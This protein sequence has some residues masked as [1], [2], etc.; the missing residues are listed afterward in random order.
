MSV[1]ILDC[2]LRDGGYVNEWNFGAKTI[3]QIV[4]NLTNACIDFVEIGF[5][6]SKPYDN[7]RTKFRF[8]SDFSPFIPADRK[9]TKYYGMITF[10][11]YD[12]ND[13][14]ENDQKSVDGFRII[15][16]KNQRQE[17][18]QYCQAVKDKGYDIFINPMHTYNY[19][20]R[21]LLDL[22]D[23]VNAI[24]PTGFSIVDTMGVMS[25]ENLVRMF[26]L[27]DHNLKKGIKVCFHSHNNLQ[28]SFTNA[29]ALC[30]LR[31]GRDIIIDVSVMG[32]GRGAGNAGLSAHA[33]P[34]ASRF[35]PHRIAAARAQIAD[36]FLHYI[37]YT[38]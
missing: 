26:M 7:D 27:I 36:K 22:I 11:D 35:S 5:L 20:D 16:K 18:L 14:P 10:G 13:L 38:P 25:S 33:A 30:E 29:K 2:T 9:K 1:S 21:E 24:N 31:T 37:Y 19:S 15:F 17:A 28:Q 4:H 8:L 23:E 3:G 32:M 34:A 12:L 6:Q